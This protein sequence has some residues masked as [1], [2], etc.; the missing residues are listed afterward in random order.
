M[1]DFTPYFNNYNH[2]ISQARKSTEL[3]E[4]KFKFYV[5][6][7]RFLGNTMGRFAGEFFLDFLL[8]GW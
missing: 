7:F 2:L 5:S 4:G 8:D 1:L 3:L 6:F